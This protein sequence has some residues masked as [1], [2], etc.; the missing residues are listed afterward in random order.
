MEKLL[1]ECLQQVSSEA[2][3]ER[4]LLQY[5]RYANELRPLLQL[6][7]SARALGGSIKIP[8]AGETASLRRFL[9][10]VSQS[11]RPR[12]PF[13]NP[14]AF[15]LGYVFLAL[16][17][18]LIVIAGT[19]VAVSAHSLPGE[20][21][22]AVKIAA[23]NTRLF[24]VKNPVQRLELEETFDQER[25]IEVEELIQHS[26]SAPVI[27][28]G[29]LSHMSPTLWEVGDVK[30]ILDAQTLVS[31]SVQEGYQ[32]VVRGHL[33]PDGSLV[34]DQVQPRLFQFSGRIQS[35]EP[36]RWIVAGIPVT[37]TANTIL[38][39]TP[40]S[41]SQ[42]DVQ[43]VLVSGGNLEALEI[44]SAE[45]SQKQP[46]STVGEDDVEPGKPAPGGEGTVSPDMTKEPSEQDREDESPQM[47]PEE[48]EDPVI[49]PTAAS[50]ETSEQIKEPQEANHEYDAGLETGE[51]PE[52]HEEIQPTQNST[53]LEH[54]QPGETSES[55]E[56]DDR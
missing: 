29:V 48:Q 5:P 42:V 34:A 35:Q 32:V 23:E 25:E 10:A 18:I 27:L 12:R 4:V 24:L 53:L 22:Y 8:P 44:S 52:S 56:S 40:V 13:F 49:A 1:E 26:R 46:T 55:E 16:F 39:G 2:D 6:A 19:S 11:R 20:P 28:T 15:R 3:L 37:I 43:A 47:E 21:L 33:R 45:F 14:A 41:G 30:V 50:T 36:L 51:T 38:S 54:A 7:L 9:G 31:G 17:I